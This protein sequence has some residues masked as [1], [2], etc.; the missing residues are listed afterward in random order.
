MEVHPGGGGGGGGR[1]GRVLTC[2]TVESCEAG[3]ASTDI[4]IDEI[5]TKP[6]N[7][8][9]R[10]ALVDICYGTTYSFSII[11]RKGKNT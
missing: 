7:A 6:V 1:G 3:N 9:V 10:V 4:L 5:T 8:R 2:V 11:Y